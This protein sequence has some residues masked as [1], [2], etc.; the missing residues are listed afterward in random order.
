MIAKS[1]AAEVERR[2]GAESAISS[3]SARTQLV[4]TKLEVVRADWLLQ[5]VDF[6]RRF[7]WVGRVDRVQRDEID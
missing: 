1:F 5:H 4:E 2:R 3:Y 6:V 7:C